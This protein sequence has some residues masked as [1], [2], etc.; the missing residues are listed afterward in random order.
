M[1]SSS[2]S[3][4]L[5]TAGGLQVEV[6]DQIDPKKPGVLIGAAGV[7]DAQVPVH[8]ARGPEPQGARGAGGRGRFGRAFSTA[9]C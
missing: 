7:I 4:L 1:T 2:S 6:F 3:P 5:L 8:A 9:A